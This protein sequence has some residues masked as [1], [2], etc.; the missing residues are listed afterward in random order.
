MTQPEYD[1]AVIG[2][3]ISHSRSPDIHAEFARQT[4]ISMQYGR[5]DAEPDQFEETVRQFF[6][7]GGRGLNITVPYKERAFDM[8]Q[9]HLSQRAR[10]AGAVN[11]LW[12]KDAM[13]HGCNTDGVGLVRDLNRLGTLRPGIKILIL[14]AG[15][16]ARGVVGPLREQGCGLLMIA[17]R[18]FSKAD[19]LVKEHIALHPQDTGV[20]TACSLNDP[21]LE[22]DWDLIINA[23]SSSLGGATIELP[24]MAFGNDTFIYDM[25]YGAKPT[26]FLD[27]AARHRK[28]AMADGLGMLV[29]QAAESFRIWH[30]IEPAVD[31][32][33]EQIR[34]QLVAHVR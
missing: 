24:D 17:N 9:P 1:F 32:V 34:M 3:P 15:G 31:A 27:Y 6:A 8:A 12:V 16:A 14:G 29:C 4:G 20:I 33:I 26:P 2:H 5:I 23:T 21:R 30:G 13:I 22:Q 25:M 18:T 11:T 28:L 7:N 10:E 19:T